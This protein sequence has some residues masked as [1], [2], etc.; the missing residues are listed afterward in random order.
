[1]NFFSADGEPFDKEPWK[2]RL[3][4]GAVGNLV[5]TRSGALFGSPEFVDEYRNF[6]AFVC[7]QT[8]LLRSSAKAIEGSEFTDQPSRA[9][10]V[11]ARGTAGFWSN[12]RRG[13]H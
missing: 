4:A 11:P 8:T 12:D 6:M 1:V 5:K 13:M 10:I 7:L 2:L 9:A 3:E